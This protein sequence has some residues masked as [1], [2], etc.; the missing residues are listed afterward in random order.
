MTRL[1]RKQEE[2]DKLYGY[3]AAALRNNDIMWLQN[4]QRRIDALEKEIIEIRN[5]KPLMLKDILDKEPEHVKN[6]IYKKFLKISIFADV[7]N[8]ACFEV[9]E[10][11]VRLGI[12]DFS[13]R[14]EVEEMNKLSQKVASFVLLPGNR[15][16]ED[17]IVENDEV[18]RGCNILADRYLNDKLKL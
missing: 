5:H 3:R 9:R 1:E 12:E 4:N 7:V 18:V 8:N 6:D 17:F 10:A 14:A 15:C 2:L 11:L 16:L 13:L